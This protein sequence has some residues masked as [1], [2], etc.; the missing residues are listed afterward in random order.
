MGKRHAYFTIREKEMANKYMKTYFISLLVRLSKLRN[1]ILLNGRKD[2]SQELVLVAGGNI[3][4][5]PLL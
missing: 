3:D 4:L 1:S 5:G 2:M